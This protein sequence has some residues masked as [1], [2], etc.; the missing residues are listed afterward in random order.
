M[1]K[2]CLSLVSS[3]LSYSNSSGDHE[4]FHIKVRLTETRIIADLNFFYV[5][6]F[7]SFMLFQLL[8][9][10]LKQVQFQ[11]T[12]LSMYFN[13]QKFAFNQWRTGPSVHRL[14]AGGPLF[15]ENAPLG[16]RFNIQRK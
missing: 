4:G 8:L 6:L 16:N 15:D 14:I 5:F 2:I 12:S 1:Q 11:E 9:L 7:F 3:I 13:W 10:E